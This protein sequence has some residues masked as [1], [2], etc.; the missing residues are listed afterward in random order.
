MKWL[1]KLNN[2]LLLVIN[3]FVA[4]AILFA[5]T[6]PELLD[7]APPRADSKATEQALFS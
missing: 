5:A 2:P 1:K 4:G 6:S 7:S 3:G